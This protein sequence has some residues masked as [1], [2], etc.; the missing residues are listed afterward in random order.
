MPRHSSLRSRP[1]NDA[2]DPFQ[3]RRER[4]KAAA[5]RGWDGISKLEAM[6][7][8]GIDVA[9]VYPSRGLFAQ[10][11]DDVDPAFAAAIA[12]AYND[13]LH[14]CKPDPNRLLGAGMISPHDVRDAVEEAR[15][16]VEDC[17]FRAIF[18]RP[19]P[20]QDRNWH[21]AY[22]EPLWDELERLNVPLGFHEGFG[23]YLPQ[24]GDRFGAD[25]QMVHTA[26]HPMEMMLAVISMISGRG[27]RTASQS[28][29]C[30]PEG[31]CSWVPFL[32]WRLDEHYEV[33]F[34]RPDSKL[35]MKPSEYFKRQ[36]RLRGSR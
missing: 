25:I 7:T 26:C 22:F 36:C 16:A 17:G 28:A 3:K 6:D 9:V 29:R 14:D 4:F 8:E 19:N 33:T 24:V 31:N 10:A 2:E 27:V 1:R 21:D 20:V 32:L 12:R 35:T 13:W 11:I 18:V 15:R 34:R 5:E 30:L 23:P